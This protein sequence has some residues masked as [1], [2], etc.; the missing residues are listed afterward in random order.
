[1]SPSAKQVLQSSDNRS[2]I[3]AVCSASTTL[4]FPFNVGE[5]RAGFRP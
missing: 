4:N 2:F 1:M 5:I 3:R